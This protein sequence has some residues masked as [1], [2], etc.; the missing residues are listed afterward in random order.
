MLYV[1]LVDAGMGA[2]MEADTLAVIAAAA[3]AEAAEV[4]AAAV[5]EVVAVVEIEFRTDRIAQSLRFK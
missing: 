5:V 2:G 1:R 3:V 4:A